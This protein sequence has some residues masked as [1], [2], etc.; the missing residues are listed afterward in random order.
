ML[1]IRLAA[2]SPLVFFPRTNLAIF[3]VMVRRFFLLFLALFPA[4]LVFAQGK[5]E[6]DLTSH[7]FGRIR[8]EAGKVR[9]KFAFKNTGTGKVILTDVKPGCGC[10]TADYSKDSI[11]PG[12]RG[13][14]IVQYDPMHRP[15]KFDKTIAVSTNGTPAAINLKISGEVIP[16][17][18]TPR[19]LYPFD[20][21]HLRLR[22]NQFVFGRINKEEVKQLSTVIY[23]EFS[24]P[25][26]ID[27]DR[28]NA[29]L[30]EYLR[31][32]ITKK[33]IQP[34]DTAKITL[35]YYAALKNDWGFC[36][37]DFVLQTN[38]TEIPVKKLSVSAD[39]REKFTPADRSGAPRAAL[40][41]TSADMG[42]HEASESPVTTFRLTNTGE[43]T[44]IIRKVQ[45]FCPC[46][47]ALVEQQALLP[48]ESALIQVEFTLAGRSGDQEKELQLITNDPVNPVQTFLVKAKVNAPGE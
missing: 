13:Y 24:K 9:V 39:I 19:D 1:R 20:L 46:T 7:S 6:F 2:R 30:P 42:T 14:V 44:L 26:V 36:F 18:K 35:V 48:G 38:D 31:L 12:G 16:R 25:M 27:L 4:V 41:K 40:D 5:I 10:T 11:L 8:E 28:T 32:K 43:S 34:A 45:A 29:G 47:R 22:T 17:E 3:V 33:V 37:E 15:G 21:G 23:N